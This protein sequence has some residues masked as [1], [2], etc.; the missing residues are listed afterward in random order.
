MMATSTDGTQIVLT[1]NESLDSSNVPSTN[2]F[3]VTTAG[4]DNSVSAVSI[5]GREVTLTVGTTIKNDE[6][7][8]VAYKDPTSGDDTNAIQDNSGNESDLSSTSVTNNSE[9]TGKY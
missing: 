2:D 1:Y 3:E 6:A 7:V 9:V 5:S 8:T 4:S